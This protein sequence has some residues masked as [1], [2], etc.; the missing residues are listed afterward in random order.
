MKSLIVY[1]SKTG[2]TKKLADAVYE[3]IAGE[4]DIYAV[5]KAPDPGNY[6][7][8]AAGFWLMAGKPDPESMEYLKRI[9]GD[10]SVFLFATHGAAAG[11]DHAKKAID[12]AGTLVPAGA[13]KGAFS[14]E[15]KVDPKVMEK[16][17]AKENPPEWLG[18]APAAEGHP[19][20][21]DIDKLK[22][23]VNSL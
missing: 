15:G 5:D 19:D 20:E 9:N 1:S 21:G 2:N 8:I 6:D 23:V 4:K 11:S 12:H 16:I 14:C 10:Q 3:S 22:Q 7:F 13:V 17:R 18:H